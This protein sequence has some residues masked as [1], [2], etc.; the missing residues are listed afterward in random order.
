MTC[1]RRLPL[2]VLMPGSGPSQGKSI[3]M[4]EYELG[5]ATYVESV[6][7]VLGA[8]ETARA[9]SGEAVDSAGG[10]SWWPHRPA[11]LW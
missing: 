4:R 9:P 11:N 1:P 6:L 3:R 5:H 8:G 7:R 10:V 2:L